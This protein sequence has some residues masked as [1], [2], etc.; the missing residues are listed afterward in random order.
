MR[1]AKQA[2]VGLV[3][4]ATTVIWIGL[5]ET[6]NQEGTVIHFSY[7]R[8]VNGKKTRPSVRSPLAGAK[9]SLTLTYGSS[10]TVGLCG[11]RWR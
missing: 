3:V 6:G 7:Q 5:R 11:H 4:V 1:S 2:L 9:K 8:S 10:P